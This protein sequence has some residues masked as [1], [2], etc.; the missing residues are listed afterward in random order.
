MS[1]TKWTPGPWVWRYD[2]WLVGA[3]GES[4]LEASDNGASYGMHS[5]VI[6]HHYA[7]AVAA[8]NK[9][10]IA[11]APAMAEALEEAEDAMNT[12]LNTCTVIV[13]KYP[14]DGNIY[15]HEKWAEEE[16]TKARDNLRAILARLEGRE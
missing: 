14:D 11:E 2:N 10:L 13:G 6:S 12:L 3:D 4:V 5:C 1:A 16:L 7:P 8:A 9:R 15:E